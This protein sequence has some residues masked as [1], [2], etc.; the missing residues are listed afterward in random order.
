MSSMFLF[1]L[2]E[3]TPAILACYHVSI[4]MINFSINIYPALV[5]LLPSFRFSA[6]F[7]LVIVGNKK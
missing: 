7:I 1:M 3:I 2:Q 5:L 4:A 6:L